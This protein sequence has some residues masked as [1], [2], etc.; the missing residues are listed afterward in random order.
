MPIPNKSKMGISQIGLNRFCMGKIIL[1]VLVGLI[2]EITVLMRLKFRLENP[3]EL[4][5]SKNLSQSKNGQSFLGDCPFFIG[6]V[7]VLFSYFAIDHI[8]II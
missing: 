4:C 2:T 7:R 3:D 5:L 1:P 8:A 6:S